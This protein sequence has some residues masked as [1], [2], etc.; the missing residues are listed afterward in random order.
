M[1]VPPEPAFVTDHARY[2]VLE[3]SEARRMGSRL[4]LDFELTSDEVWGNM[5]GCCF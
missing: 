3:K 4:A 5:V 2:E 1:P